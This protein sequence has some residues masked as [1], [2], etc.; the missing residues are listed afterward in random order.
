MKIDAFLAEY[1]STAGV[2]DLDASSSIVDEHV[3]R[4]RVAGRERD[5]VDVALAE[6]I[7]ATLH[8]L[9]L[10]AEQ[11]TARERALLFGA[12]KYFAEH[13]DANSDLSSP[14]GFDD[15]AGVLNAV[16]VYL[17]RKDLTLVID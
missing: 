11:Y 1:I 9:L 14:T 15:D 4:V 8:Q 3:E 5:F 2:S 13:D 17:G 6:R 12:V 16:C 7:A 10:T